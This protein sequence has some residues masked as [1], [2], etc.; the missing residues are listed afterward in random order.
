M[1][2]IKLKQLFIFVFNTH[3]FEKWKTS[4]IVFSAAIAHTYFNK[5]RTFFF[6][7]AQTNCQVAQIYN[8][9]LP[10]IKYS[11]NFVKRI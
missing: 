1:A 9:Y 10:A 4:A 5:Q 7:V 3:V 6:Q 8:C 11:L 2:F